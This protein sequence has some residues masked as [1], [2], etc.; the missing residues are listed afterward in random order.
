M[1]G[2]NYFNRVL[3]A[4]MFIL[5]VLTTNCNKIKNNDDKYEDISDI[6]LIENGNAHVPSSAEDIKSLR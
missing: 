4:M 6:S 2:G 3:G 5:C 1:V